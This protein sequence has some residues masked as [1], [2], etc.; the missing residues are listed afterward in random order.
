MTSSTR[1]SVVV[2]PFWRYLVSSISDSTKICQVSSAYIYL[3]VIDKH[4]K[5]IFLIVDIDIAKKWK[6]LRDCF[7]TCSRK[8]S[9]NLNLSTRQRDIFKRCQFL[10]PYINHKTVNKVFVPPKD[11]SYILSPNSQ[12]AKILCKYV[13][14]YSLQLIHLLNTYA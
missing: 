5:N 1:Q 14:F 12:V 8:L 4:L 7:C 9:N 13:E 11:Y 10:L 2:Q 3:P 6:Y